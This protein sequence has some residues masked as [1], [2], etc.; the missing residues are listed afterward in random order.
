VTVKESPYSFKNPVLWGV[1]ILYTIV[2]VYTM[3][4]HELWGDEVHS[5]NIAKAS[6]GFLD[7]IANTR[8][9]GH[10]PLWYIILWTISKFTQD[11][12]YMQLIHLVIA[13][14]L[15]ILIL[16]YSPFPFITRI[17]IPFGYFFIYEY[18]ILSRNYAIGVLLAFFICLVIHGNFKYKVLLYYILLFL[19]SNTHLVALL[20]AASF[21]LYFLLSQ[22]EGRKRRTMLAFHIL[23]GGIIFLFSLYFISPPSDSEMNAGFWMSRW[24]VNQIN[25]VG[26]LPLI[27]FVPLP[28]WWNDHFWNTEFLLEAKNKYRLLKFLNPVIVLILL[29]AICI[30][31]RKYKKSLIL[32]ITNLALSFIVTIAVFPLTTPRYSGF[33]FIGFIVA[34]WLYCYQTSA[35]RRNTRLVNILLIIQ[36]IAGSFIVS[37]DIRLPFSNANKINEILK[38][39][40]QNEKIVTDYWAINTISAFADKSFYCIDM[41]KEMSYLLWNTELANV[42]KRPNRY[43]IGINTLFQKEGIRKLYLVSTRSPENLFKTDSKLATFFQVILIDKREGAIEKGSNLYLYEISSL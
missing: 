14:M 17:L 39:V 5:W 21:H 24:N 11:P 3:L 12:V 23:I 32:F 20:L 40:P 27:A 7:L 19:M 36:I 25:D 13:C 2:A 35:D 10:P 30:I 9:E 34:Y 6:V 4:H 26:Q 18:S 33:I 31:L 16:F 28:A 15:V 43:Y 22:I 41:Q 38:E 1:L 29:G 37:K 42:L 8:Y